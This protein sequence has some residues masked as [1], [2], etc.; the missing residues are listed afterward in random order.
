MCFGVDLGPGKWRLE[1]IPGLQL[2]GRP[3]QLIL[4]PDII[5]GNA[6]LWEVTKLVSST[7]NVVAL[8]GEGRDGS[9]NFSIIGPGTS[10]DFILNPES[11]EDTLVVEIKWEGVQRQPVAPPVQN[12]KV[13]HVMASRESRK[14]T[15]FLNFPVQEIDLSAIESVSDLL[16]SISS[17]DS[18][19][20]D[21]RI[22]E[23]PHHAFEAG[24]LVGSAKPIQV[25]VSPGTYSR[26]E[27]LSDL[28]GK[29]LVTLLS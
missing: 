25:I 4:T 12:S 17:A 8:R 24:L 23:D 7:G 10:E 13:L 3:A 22:F 26:N 6:F 27:L 5:N 19:L 20:V 29:K 16:T 28:L 2:G 18:I 21:A 11:P 9:V 1:T 15:T 14:T